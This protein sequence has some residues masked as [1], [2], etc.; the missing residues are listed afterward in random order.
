MR[1]LRIIGVLL[2]VLVLLLVV[3][4]RVA[5]W[6]AER[7]VADKVADELAERQVDSSSPE[8][9]IH[10]VPFLT[11][12]GAG[13]F[14]EVTVRLRDVDWAGIR[15]ARVELAAT[16]VTASTGTV[17]TGEGPIDAEWLHGTATIGYATLAAL[18][19]PDEL[20]GLRL[21]PD[22]D[23]AL[24]VSLPAEVLG[25]PVTLAGVAG[26]EVTDGRVQLRIVELSVAEGEL[27]AGAGPLVDELVGS[28]TQRLTLDVALPALPYGL[29]LESV[30]AEPA[31]L[32]VEVSARDVPLV[33]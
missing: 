19:G 27:P 25:Q 32:V 8:V 18:P 20:A 15:L 24:A 7:T 31:G 1:G 23:G 13:R 30:R 12:V 29:T 11:Q 17:L 21:T 28:V 6:A 5:V 22:E 10:G 3:A 16:G 14:D 9:S 33:R 4:D 26:V 2:V